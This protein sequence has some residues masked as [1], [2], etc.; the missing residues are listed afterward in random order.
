MKT[1]ICGPPHSGKSVLIANLIRFMPSDSYLRINAN[2]DGEGSWSNN[3]DQEEIARVRIKSSNTAD[4]FAIW[5]ENIKQAFQDVVL[6]DIGGRLQDDKAPLFEAADSFIV[7][8]SVS[9]MIS[10]WKEFGESHGCHCLATVES[11]LEGGYDEII[12][13]EHDYIQARLSGLERGRFLFDS[14]VIKEL[15][16]LIVSVSGYRRSIFL[17]FSKVGE[18]IGCAME[19]TTSNGVRVTHSHFNHEHGYLIYDY[20]S[21]LVQKGCRYNIIGLKANWVAAIAS[22]V[23][24][25][26]SQVSFFDDRTGTFKPISPIMKSN[27]SGKWL[28]NEDNDYVLLRQ[29]NDDFFHNLGCEANTIPVLNE[30][31]PLFLSARLPLWVIASIFI[32]YSSTKKYLF[33]PGNHYICVQSENPQELGLIKTI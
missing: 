20:L 27:T 15:A 28:V 2:G 22:S 5:T 30:K 31:K 29:K 24:W 18:S 32:S 3:A 1:I 14:K 17:D 11:Y 10:A 12:V 8:S 16:D 19:W 9:D 7:L 25:K 4:K 33:Q 23:L 13:R 21:G 26:H 6:V